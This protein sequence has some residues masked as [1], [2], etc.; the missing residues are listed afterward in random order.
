MINKS[1]ALKIFEKVKKANK[2]LLLLHVSPDPDGISSVLS[3]DLVLNRLGKKTKIISY[4]QIPL[5]FGY[6]PGIEKVE[7]FDFARINFSDFDLFISLDCAGKIMVTRSD[8]PEK[9]PKNFQIINIDHHPTNEK[10]GKI[11]LVETVS[12]TAEILYRLFKIWKIKI[13]KNLA[14]LLLAGIFSDS[15]CFQYS[16]ATPDTFLAVADLTKRGASVFENVLFIFRSYSMKTLKYWG[17]VLD[18]MKIDESGKFIWSVFSKSE[19]EEIGVEPTEIDM[20]A[21]NFAPIVKGTEFGIILLEEA[22]NLIRGS[23]RS[24][25]DFDVSK[26]ALELGG[27]GHKQAAGFSLKMP[28]P[29]AEEKVLEIAREFLRQEMLGMRKD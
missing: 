20:A 4:S 15:G 7:T 1:T 16:N 14:S 25:N 23:L 18:K 5:R 8:F 27:G 9:F 24:R 2:I 3:L 13:D 6:I 12:S 29:K 21:S 17:K 11:N 28:L 22:E 26:I 19:R 10:F